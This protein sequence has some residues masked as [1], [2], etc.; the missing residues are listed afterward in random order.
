MIEGIQHSSTPTTAWTRH[1]RGS[2]LRRMPLELTDAD[3]AS[4]AMACR[5]MAYQ[6]SRRAAAMEN[7]TRRG[8]VDAASQRYAQLAEKLEAA[9]KRSHP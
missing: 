2:T 3:L 7:P 9:R 1:A 5:A 6:E 4:A 8:P